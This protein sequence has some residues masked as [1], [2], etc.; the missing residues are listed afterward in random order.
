MARG[1]RGRVGLAV[2]LAV[3][4]ALALGIGCLVQQRAI[5]AQ[6]ARI[7]EL[8]AQ[9]DALIESNAQLRDKINFTYTDEYF[10]REAPRQ[11]YVADD[12][13]LYVGGD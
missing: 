9:R 11:G 7:A 3:C 1:R 12:E 13:T 10:R 8:T 5:D 2:A 4:G 6:N